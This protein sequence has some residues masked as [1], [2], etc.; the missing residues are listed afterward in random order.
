MPQWAQTTQ[1][2]SVGTDIVAQITHY[3]QQW[4]AAAKNNDA[5]AVA[6]L[7]SE[8]FVG[9]DADGSLHD[10]SEILA[11]I[12]SDKWEINEI[13]DIQVVVR[14]NTAIATGAWRGKGTTADGKSIDVHEQ[15]MDTWNQNGKWQCIASAS[16]PAKM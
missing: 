6:A 7:L 8:V 14:G 11:R 9:M 2:S 16:T 13:S 3:E 5:A 10:K 12:K 4:A 1:G 15:W